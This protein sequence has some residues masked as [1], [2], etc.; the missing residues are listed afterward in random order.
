MLLVQNL[1]EI[2]ILMVES[3]GRLFYIDFRKDVLS[4]VE[5]KDADVRYSKTP[6]LLKMDCSKNRL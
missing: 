1:W 5:I 6:I 4:R 2:L 3:I